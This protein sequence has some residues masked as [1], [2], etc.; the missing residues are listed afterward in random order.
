MA[1][2]LGIP[3]DHFLSKM[4]V[5]CGDGVYAGGGEDARHHGPRAFESDAFWVDPD[6]KRV[7]W[8]FFHC[9]DKAIAA[10]ANDS[11]RATSLNSFLRQMDLISGMGQGRVID[12]SCAA[13]LGCQFLTFKTP[14]RTRKGTSLL[15]CVTR[16]LAK[17]K[18]IYVAMKVRQRQS[19]LFG[20]GSKSVDELNAAASPLCDA[21]MMSFAMSLPAGLG[22]VLSPF[23]S[24]L[25]SISD[26]PWRRWE[27]RCDAL[28]SFRSI[29]AGLHR[30]RALMRLIAL[31]TLYVGCPTSVRRFWFA[32][33]LARTFRPLIHK[34]IFLPAKV[35]EVFTS[36]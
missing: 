2:D 22:N 33:C 23:A 9:L 27:A 30:V 34:S 12:K 20:R 5:A 19:I 17:F 28:V 32:Q 18:T 3:W 31:I 15:A 1:D 26:L 29:E 13:W 4:A 36:G 6:V 25:Q 10:A 21:S 16:Y 14:A 24:R 8:D 35:F 11:R 7:L